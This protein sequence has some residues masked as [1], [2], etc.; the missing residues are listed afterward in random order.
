MDDLRAC[1]VYL[2]PVVAWLPAQFVA[3]RQSIRVALR[4]NG[5]P[6]FVSRMMMA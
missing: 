5:V 6:S 4:R 2:R 1:R 3:F